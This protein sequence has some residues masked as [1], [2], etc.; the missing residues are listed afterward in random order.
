[1]FAVTY[2]PAPDAVL[3]R[4]QVASW[5]QL[6]PRQ[7]QRLGVP[8]LNLGPKTKRYLARDVLTWLETLRRGRVDSRKGA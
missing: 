5:L 7:V 6:K 4:D 8:E 3:T 1:V 2:P